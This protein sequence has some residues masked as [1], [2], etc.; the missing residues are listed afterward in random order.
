MQDFFF[1]R[2]EDAKDFFSVRCSDLLTT[3]IACHDEEVINRVPV[4]LN[5]S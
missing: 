1:G 2:E 3:H 4:T 5:A